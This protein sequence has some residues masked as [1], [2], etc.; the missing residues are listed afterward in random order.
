GAGLLAVDPDVAAYFDAAVAAGREKGVAATTIAHWLTGDLFRWLKSENAGIGDLR[1]GPQ[2]LVDLLA[3]VEQGTITA[4]SGRL[5]L[6]E[7]LAT[8]RPAA[9]IAAARGMA[10]ISEQSA[11]AGVVDQ[12]IA[13]NPDLVDQYRGG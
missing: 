7:M 2:A 8:G 6:D 12:V 1:A 13:A 5:V 11:L 4:A 9:E 3:L 10:Q